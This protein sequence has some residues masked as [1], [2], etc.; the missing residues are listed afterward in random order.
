MLQ[1]HKSE[2]N[3]LIAFLLNLSFS[4]YEF[5]GGALTGS[6]AIVSDAIHDIGDAMSIGVS[7][8]LERKSKKRPNETYNYGYQ[9]FSVLGSLITTVILLTGSIFV[10]YSAIRRMINPV[11]I[12]YD[13]MIILAVIGLIVNF[14]AA[15][16][17][18][19][20]N[21]LNQK[22]V[23]LHMLEDVLG[24]AVVL[25]GAIVMRLTGF[26]IIDPILSIGVA[27]FI[28]KNAFDNFLAIMDV[29]L[30]K[31][32]RNISLPEL[33]KH[34]HKIPDVKGVHHMH[35][36]SMDG[37]QNYATLHVVG[38]GDTGKLK[39]AIRAE[40]AKY[41]IV[42]TTIEIESPTEICTEQQCEPKIV[43]ATHAHHHHH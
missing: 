31:T 36:W 6:V 22:S 4:I 5:I 43:S 18:R 24:W 15:W 41:D 34:L 1:K 2:R 9:R 42:H 25:V 30:E 27:I 16:F 11:E 13:G 35:I 32:P 17:T 39:Q 40:L 37:Y 12:H 21:S 10:V 38:T 3:I 28:F 7:Y 33:E 26:S 20:G 23:N 29:F 14:L 8:F 19:D